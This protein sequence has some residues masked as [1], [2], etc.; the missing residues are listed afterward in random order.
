MGVEPGSD[1]GA[2]QESYKKLAA[3]CEPSRFPAGSKEA[4]DV[5]AIRKKLDAS[6]EILRD[7]LDV[8]ARRF[9]LLDFDD[10]PAN[11]ATPPTSSL[12]L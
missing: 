4:Q 3:R 5:E 12:E 7:A 6:F 2:V 1:F 10:A 8:T 11:G 9:G